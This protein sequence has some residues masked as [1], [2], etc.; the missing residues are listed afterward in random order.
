MFS[1]LIIHR[2]EPIQIMHFKDC[3]MCRNERDESDFSDGI[4]LEYLNRSQSFAA[5]STEFVFEENAFTLLARSLT[6]LKRDITD[7]FTKQ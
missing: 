5:G 7:K 6:R 4:K 1:S 3:F 2:N